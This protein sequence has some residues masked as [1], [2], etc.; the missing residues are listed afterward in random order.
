VEVRDGGDEK[1]G[2]YNDNLGNMYKEKEVVETHTE[3]NTYTYGGG[4]EGV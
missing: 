4:G 2:E 3:R 1:I